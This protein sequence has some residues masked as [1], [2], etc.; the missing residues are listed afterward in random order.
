[1]GIA[2]FL[3]YKRNRRVQFCEMLLTIFD[4]KFFIYVV[5]MIKREIK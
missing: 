5:P 1:M 2:S 3:L 4:I